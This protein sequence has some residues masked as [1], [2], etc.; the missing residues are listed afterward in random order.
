MTRYRNPETGETD[1]RP[2]WILPAVTIG[3]LLVG[4]DLIDVRWVGNGESL[5]SDFSTSDAYST[6]SSDKSRRD[7][8]DDSDEATEASDAAGLPPSIGKGLDEQTG[9]VVHTADG[10]T[11]DVDF[12]GDVTSVPMRIR[13]TG[14]NTRELKKYSHDNNKIQGECHGV[15]ATLRGRE[16]LT[17]KT[18]RITARD[19]R[20]KSGH[21]LRRSIAYSE[22]GEWRDYGATMIRESLAFPHGN[23]SEWSWNEEYLNLAK[24]VSK[25][26]KGVWSPTACGIGPDP[27]AQLSVALNNADEVAT[28]TNNG[29]KPV[30]LGGWGIG[31]SYPR[32]FILPDATNIPAGG[33]IRVHTGSGRNTDTD[34]YWGLP[35]AAYD[36]ESGPPRHTF[37]HAYLVDPNLDLRAWSGEHEKAE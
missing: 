14:I 33:S 27:D 4:P 12:D 34:I 24:Q 20:S 19:E 7:R 8:Y 23:G 3:A 10:D 21:R 1:G 5:R 9:K 29:T 36:N 25:D 37:D 16:L 11:V 15:A 30:P 32:R 18:V 28:I 26:K 13:L 22:K 35:K 6:D 17:G 31:D 2:G